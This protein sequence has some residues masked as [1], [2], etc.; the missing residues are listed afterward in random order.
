MGYKTIKLDADSYF[1]LTAIKNE[2][3]TNLNKNL[4]FTIFF[5]KP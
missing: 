2:N 5:L 1:F 4:L 3:D